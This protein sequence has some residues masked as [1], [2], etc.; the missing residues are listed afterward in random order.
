MKV[1]IG[2]YPQTVDVHRL[3]NK[4]FEMKYKTPYWNID[5]DALDTTD[6][7][8]IFVTDSINSV[9]DATINQIIK[10]QKRKV[11]VTINKN[12]IWSSDSTLAHVIHPLLLKLAE[13]K[14]GAPHIDDE[15]VPEALQSTNADPKENEW[16]TDSN[17]FARWDYVLDEMLWTFEQYALDDSI[18][19]HDDEHYERRLNGT[20]LFGKYYSSL[21]V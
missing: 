6:K 13:C 17:W 14:S 1:N 2:N 5:D 16:D 9:L 18:Y 11:K 4:Y 15:D 3:H 12:D 7:L 10:R 20:K 21:W 19:V 8:V